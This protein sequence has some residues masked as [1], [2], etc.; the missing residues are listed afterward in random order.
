MEESV[1]NIDQEILGGTPVFSEIR[2][3]IKNLFDFG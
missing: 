1:I 3:P 2:V